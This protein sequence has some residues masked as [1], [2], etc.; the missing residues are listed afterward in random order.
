VKA[1]ETGEQEE[2]NLEELTTYLVKRLGGN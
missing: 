2:V 1:M